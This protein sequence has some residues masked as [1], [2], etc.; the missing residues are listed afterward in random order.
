[1]KLLFKNML[2]NMLVLMVVM[3]PLPNVFAMPMEMSTNH[4][5]AGAV[6]VEMVIMNHAGHDMSSAKLQDSELDKKTAAC[7]C[8]NQCDSDCTGCV[9]ISSAITFEFLELSNLNDVEVVSIMTD[10]LLTRTISPP[11]RPPLTL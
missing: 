1:M 4:C 8:C 2:V 9:H 3:L 6:D 5:K 7:A 11:S 10:S